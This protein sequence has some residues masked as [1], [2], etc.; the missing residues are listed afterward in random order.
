MNCGL[1]AVTIVGISSIILAGC[2]KDSKVAGS[3]IS[4]EGR[5]PVIR[6]VAEK[7]LGAEAYFINPFLPS[8]IQTPGIYAIR[9]SGR[10]IKICEHDTNQQ[11]AIKNMKAANISTKHANVLKDRLS[12]VRIKVKVLGKPYEL[13]YKKLVVAGYTVIR[14][15]SLGSQTAEQYI[16]DNVGENCPGV[17]QKNRPYFIVTQV[18]IADRIDTVSGGGVA[19]LEFDI[20]IPIVNTAASVSIQLQDNEPQTETNVVFAML[21]KVVKSE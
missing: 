8:G 2:V 6:S 10:Y 15:P 13:P 3:L 4:P 5:I 21:G 11:R 16:I 19:D 18:A 17:L 7:A 1:K 14:S 12:P 20:P 9:D